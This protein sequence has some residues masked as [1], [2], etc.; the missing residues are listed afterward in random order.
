MNSNKPR[1]AFMGTPGFSA[2]ILKTLLNSYEYQVVAVYTQPPRP[3]GRGYKVT[4]SPVEELATAH[5]IPV[6]SPPSLK[7]EEAQTQW[8]A[9][10]LDV[11]VVAAYGLILPPAILEAPKKGCL[12]IHV[13]LL[14]RWRGAAPIQR[15][16]LAGDKETGVSIMKMDTG[17]DTGDILLMK[18]IALDK[19]MTTPILQDKLAHLGTEAILEALP[20]YLK[21]Q[22]Q[23]V[24]QPT[25]GIT[26]A[27]K[28]AKEEGLLDWHLPA[29]VLERKVRALNPWPGTWLEIGDD[30]IKV[31]AAEVISQPFSE[32]PG[33][34]LDNRFTIACSTGALRLLRVQKV[35]KMALSA[36]EFLRG[37]ELPSTNLSHAA[38]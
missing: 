8:S 33:T 14:P 2:F 13:S 4:P 11:G 34:V 7:S 28:L 32:R 16:I 18:K 1:I 20:L 37:Y 15:A 21:D 31:L 12:N 30:R 10:D 38:A 23:L 5:N 27:E 35:G 29:D 3:V 9:L 17:L 36:D 25:E 19:T 6:F 26:Y 22:L 24:P